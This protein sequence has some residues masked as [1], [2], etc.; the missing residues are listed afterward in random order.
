VRAVRQALGQLSESQREVVVLHAYEGMT[1]AEIAE[2]LGATGV[3][4]RVRA[5]RAYRRLRELLRPIEEQR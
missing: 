4:V 1:F 5:H 2:V 3:A